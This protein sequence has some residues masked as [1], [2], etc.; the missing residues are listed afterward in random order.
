MTVISKVLHLCRTPQTS[1]LGR[2][3]SPQQR[4]LGQRRR[5]TVT[6]RLTVRASA[7]ALR[8]RSCLNKRRSI[9]SL[10]CLVRPFHHQVILMVSRGEGPTGSGK[11]SLLM[12]LMGEMHY[13]PSGPG[14]WYNLPREGGV[15]YAAQESWVLNETIKVCALVLICD[16]C[17]TYFG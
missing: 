12:A 13:I 16:D 6:L 14:S 11:T 7:C 15:A 3:A 8:S 9:L 10:V 1:M 2:L 4:S 5:P 17:N